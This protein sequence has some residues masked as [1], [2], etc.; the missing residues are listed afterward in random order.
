MKICLIETVL[1]IKIQ[2]FYEIDFSN[3]TLKKSVCFL[4]ISILLSEIRTPFR[5]TQI[6]GLQKVTWISSFFSSKQTPQGSNK[7]TFGCLSSKNLGGSDWSLPFFSKFFQKSK[8]FVMTRTKC[9][10]ISFILKKFIPFGLWFYLFVME[11]IMR[12]YPVLPQVSC[13]FH[14]KQ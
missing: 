4:T 5:K 14:R 8:K 9:R 11:Y 3:L 6:S 13:Y 7:T 12:K 1:Y 2:L 10:N